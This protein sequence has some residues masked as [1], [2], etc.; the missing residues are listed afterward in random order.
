MEKKHY[1]FS[2]GF[3]LFLFSAIYLVIKPAIWASYDL[4]DTGQIGDTIGGITAPFINLLGAILVFVSFLE[5][6]KANKL[7]SEQNTFVLFHELYKDLKS[8]FNNLC[9]SSSAIKNGKE[10][11]G[12]KAFSLFTNT[13]EKRI[14]S[15]SFPKNSFFDEVVF[16]I[17]NIT[18]FINTIETSNI[19]DTQK[20]YILKLLHFLYLTKIRKHLLS[21]LELIK[22]KELHKD[23]YD[24][25]FGAE[26]IIESNYRRYFEEK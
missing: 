16:L 22:D 24:T 9:F 15:Q 21:I 8:D 11:Y 13:L 10:Y 23:F 14:D 5:Q 4:T 18:I 6:N 3:V 26:K 19:D 20:K 12:K 17:G 25:L 1:I 2:I 7:L